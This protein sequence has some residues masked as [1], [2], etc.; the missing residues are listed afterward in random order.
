MLCPCNWVGISSINCATLDN[1]YRVHRQLLWDL[2]RGCVKE[3]AGVCVFVCEHT[4]LLGRTGAFTLT[5]Q[6]FVFFM[7]LCHDHNVKCTTL[8]FFSQCYGFQNWVL[9]LLFYLY[10]KPVQGVERSSSLQGF[11]GKQRRTS[12]AASQVL[13]CALQWGWSAS[14]NASFLL[15]QSHLECLLLRRSTLV[16]SDQ[17]AQFQFLSQLANSTSISVVEGWFSF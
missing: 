8:F 6:L 17:S 11:N 12:P 5:N 3:Y 1:K 7:A 2:K 16:S 4:C 9:F 10:L 14:A 15:Q 13:H